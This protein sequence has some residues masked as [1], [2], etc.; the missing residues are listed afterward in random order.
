[1][2]EEASW[3]LP[4]N[5]RKKGKEIHRNVGVEVLEE[6]KGNGSV[7][8]FF[9]TNLPP[10]CRP[11]DV[12]DFFKV[13]GTVSEAYIARKPDKEGRKF[14]FISFYNVQDVKGMER[15]ING[16]KMGD[17]RLSLI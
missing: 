2:E 9:I 3:E 10:G 17:T 14:G 13:F 16:T 6:K 4:R 5:L 7:T 11:W 15:A 1:M 8:K 12:A